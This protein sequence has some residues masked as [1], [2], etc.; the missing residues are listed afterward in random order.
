MAFYYV[1]QGDTFEV[2]RKGG[3]VWSPQ[4]NK[5]GKK[6]TGYT[7]MTCIKKGD[8]IFHNCNSYLVAISVAQTNCYEANRP[9]EL[10]SPITKWNDEGYRVDTI[11]YDLKSPLLVT[12]YKDWLKVHYKK[13]SAFTL[14]GRGKQ[15]YMCKLDETHASFLLNEMIRDN[16]LTILNNLLSETGEE[17]EYDHLEKESIE[18]I[19]TN[20][21]KAIPAWGGANTKQATKYSTTTKRIVPM[22]NAQVAADALMHARYQCENESSHYTFLRKNGLPYTEPHHLIPLSKYEDF[23]YS[24]D[25]MENIVSLCSTCHN[26]LH[27]GRFEDKEPILEKLYYERKNALKKKGI[28]LSLDQLKDYYR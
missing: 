27:Y 25:I 1:Y 19:I 17:L 24:I 7:T 4:L 9:K 11:Y 5:A 22:R 15:Q 23:D 6:N 10:V 2:E 26:L 20:S 13:E 8:V 28:D 14:V 3:Y 12:D 18:D 21:S 16:D